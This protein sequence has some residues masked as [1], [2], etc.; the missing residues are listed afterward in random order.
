M[1]AAISRVPRVGVDV[2]QLRLVLLTRAFAN[3]IALDEA[4]GVVEPS[5]V[6][7]SDGRI[8]VQWI[9]HNP[10][11]IGLWQEGDVLLGIGVTEAE[12]V[13]SRTA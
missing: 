2:A 1:T 10:A 12:P 7:V 4:V 11:T 13:F 9:A 3:A 5:N 6:G 8:E